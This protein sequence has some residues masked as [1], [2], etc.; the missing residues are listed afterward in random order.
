MKHDCVTNLELLFHFILLLLP[1]FLL[2]L[3][4]LQSLLLPLLL[5]FI[6]SGVGALAFLA[7]N[8]LDH[9]VAKEKSIFS[10]MF[11]FNP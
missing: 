2:L 1:F 8:K 4:L 5:F 11:T 10:I 3:L 6:V 9:S 7:E